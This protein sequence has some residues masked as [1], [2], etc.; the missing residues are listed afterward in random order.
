MPFQRLKRE[1]EKQPVREKRAC[2]IPQGE[3]KKKKMKTAFQ[4]QTAQLIMMVMTASL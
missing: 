4:T 1:R 2:V 3:K